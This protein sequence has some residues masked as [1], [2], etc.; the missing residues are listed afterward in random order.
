MKKREEE[1]VRDTP[2]T[3]RSSDGQ[4]WRGGRSLWRQHARGKERVRET[5][6]ECEGAVAGL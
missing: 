6:E 5:R 4:Q 1:M 3:A 2:P